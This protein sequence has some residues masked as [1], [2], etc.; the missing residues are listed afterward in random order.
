MPHP[1]PPR[2]DPDVSPRSAL[3]FS[4]LIAHLQV[5]GRPDEDRPGWTD[6]RSAFDALTADHGAGPLTDSTAK[7]IL[8]AAVAAGMLI[9]TRPQTGKHVIDGYR[10]NPFF[11]IW[12]EAH[13]TY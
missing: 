5:S 13:G 10:L 12:E 8:S 2:I 11:E 4:A 6:T 7:S 1:I 9:P 3:A